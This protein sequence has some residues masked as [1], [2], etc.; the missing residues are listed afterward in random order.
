MLDT[1]R[2]RKQIIE[3]LQIFRAL[4]D[5]AY[6][7]QHHPAV[8]MW[9]NAGACLLEYTCV[10]HHEYVV[11]RGHRV[12]E[13]QAWRWKSLHLKHAATFGITIPSW[14]LLLNLRDKYSY[15]DWRPRPEWMGDPEFHRAHRSNLL[16]KAPEHYA[17]FFEPDLPDNLPYIWPAYGRPRSMQIRLF[18]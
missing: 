11:M 2:L 18:A 6:G 8:K 7:W 16:R 15:A 5:P 13:M 17:Q 14:A 1:Q 12:M 4:H 3:A 10:L 9:S